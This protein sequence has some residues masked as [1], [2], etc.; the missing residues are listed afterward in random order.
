MTTKQPHSLFAPKNFEITDLE[1]EIKADA[2]C[3]RLLRL[4]YLHLHEEQNLAPEQ[5]S[6]LTY[7]ADYFLREFIIGDRQ[8]N[9]LKI[10]PRRINQFA[11][12]WYIVKNLEPNMEELT[13][14]LDGIRRFY[15]YCATVGLICAQ[16]AASIGRECGREAYYRQR[17]ESFWAIEGDGYLVWERECSLKS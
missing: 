14:H 17:I 10:A 9:I 3:N 4:F 7:G 1:A 16:L 5:A 13:I 6:A 15:A 11:G 8:E 2:L 12:N